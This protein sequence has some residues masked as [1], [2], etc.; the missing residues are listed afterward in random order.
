MANTYFLN[1]T[2]SAITFT[3]NGGDPRNLEALNLVNASPKMATKM[4]LGAIRAED[5]LGLGTNEVAVHIDGNNVRL[6]KVD[7][8]NPVKTNHDVQI[9]LYGNTIECRNDETTE[10]FTVTAGSAADLKPFSK[11]VTAAYAQPRRG[12]PTVKTAITADQLNYTLLTSDAIGALYAASNNDTSTAD[13]AWCWYYLFAN[14][15]PPET[16][17]FD[18]SYLDI[19]TTRTGRAVGGVERCTDQGRHQL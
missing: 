9:I 3:L 13:I 1:G 10:G 16:L 12:M 7:V 19:G 8:S 14:P 11:A 6:F 4:A 18:A 2:T 15:T 5:K 17:D